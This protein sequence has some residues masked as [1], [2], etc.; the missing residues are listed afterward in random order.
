MTSSAHQSEAEYTLDIQPVD[1]DSESRPSP[2][3]ES[4]LP[5]RRLLNLPRYRMFAPVAQ[6]DPT[7]RSVVSHSKVRRALASRLNPK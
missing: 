6:Y 4:L 2:G 5:G 1:P 3:S 7:F